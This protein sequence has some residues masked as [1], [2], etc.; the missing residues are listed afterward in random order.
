MHGPSF[1][2][3][4]CGNVESEGAGLKKPVCKKQL[5]IRPTAFDIYCIEL[6]SV[7]VLLESPPTAKSQPSGRGN[8]I[9]SQNCLILCGIHYVINPNQ[10]PW[11]SGIKLTAPKHD[12]P[13]TIFHCGYEV[14]LL[15]C[16]SVP[17]LN[18]PMLY[19]TKTC[20]C[21]LCSEKAFFWQPFQW[22]CGY[23]GGV[24]WCFL[25]PGDPKIFYC[26]PWGFCC[27]S[28][29]SPQYPGGQDAVA[30]S[31]MRFSMAPYLFNF[32]II[33]LSVLIG[34]FSEWIYSGIYCLHIF[35]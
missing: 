26:D 15:V 8:Q 35:L 16:I 6:S 3:G 29:H 2:R 18:M 9:F 1:Q 31:T 25:K 4:R 14:L 30:S 12:R 20:V 13:T 33:A 17:M 28:H 32:F 19:L 34:I 23:G 24:W 10:C 5:I 22:G 11:T 27:F 7:I 21:V